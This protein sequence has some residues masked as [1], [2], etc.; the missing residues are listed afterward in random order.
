MKTMY[1]GAARPS[2]LRGRL[3]RLALVTGVLASAPVLGA[4][5][6]AERI[7]THDGWVAYR[8][9]MV[10]DAGEPCCLNWNGKQAQRSGC[11]LD[12]RNWNFGTNLDKEVGYVPTDTLA[13]FLRVS[14]GKPDRVQALADNCPV[15]ADK[16]IAWLEGVAPEE[17]VALLSGLVRASSSRKDVD[18]MGLPALAY[19]AGKPATDSMAALAGPSQPRKLREQSLFWLGQARGE[20]GA[21]IVERTATTDPDPKLRAHA[22]FSLSQADNADVYSRIKAISASDASSHVRSQALFWMAQMGDPRAREDILARIRGDSDDDVREQG[23]F[24]LSQLPKEQG[25]EALIAVLQGD[26]P[27]ETKKRALFWHGQS[28]SPR[29]LAYFDSVLS[30]TEP[31]E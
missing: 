2:G 19:H 3:R 6:L 17:S 30:K 15:K 7:A 21:E 24:A 4:P 10:E 26:Y 18:N 16:P 23:V 13:V 1:A 12:G 11:D 22:V 14:G 27:R 8:V 31:A 29:A 5:T 28:G 9:P 20:A 25:D